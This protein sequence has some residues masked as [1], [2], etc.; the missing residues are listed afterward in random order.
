M[1]GFRKNKGIIIELTS[2]LDIIMIMLFWVMLNVS[3]NAQDI[4]KKAQEKIDEAN[5]K[6]V[7]AQQDAQEQ[8]DKIKEENKATELAAKNMQ[9]ALDGFSSGMMVSVEM[10]YSD[11]KDVIYVSRNNSEPA[12]VEVND[13]LNEELS[14]ALDSYGLTKDSI[15]LA[16]F[17]YDGDKVLY[18]D[19]NK[20]LDTLGKIKGNYKN[21]YFTQIN[22]TKQKGEN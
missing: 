13:K 14:K 2:L 21:I 9:D 10:R 17:M 20:V 22:T 19:V 8:I 16:A 3:N 5:A 15:I 18:R 11:G 4:E 7:Q 6:T 12:A 1:N